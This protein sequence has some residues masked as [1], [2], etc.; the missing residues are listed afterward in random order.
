[1]LTNKIWLFFLFAISPWFIFAQ[2]SMHEAQAGKQLVT[3]DYR[4][5]EDLSLE[6][7]AD[8]VKLITK[9]DLK[10]RSSPGAKSPIIGSIDRGNRVQQLDII[11]DYYLVCYKG[12]CGY[13][14][15]DH[16]SRIMINEDPVRK[17]RDS[18]QV[19]KINHF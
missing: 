8:D 12:D 1:M 16:L 13:V 6:L 2:K 10:L 3:N 15:K 17:T 4:Q 14:K 18:I 11:G 9:V 5:D 19:L 7:G